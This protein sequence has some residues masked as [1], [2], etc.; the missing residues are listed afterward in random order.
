MHRVTE[1]LWMGI[2]IA[3]A[4]AIHYDAG[5]TSNFARPLN[6][7]TLM[8]RRTC[9]IGAPESVTWGRCI[10]TDI[11]YRLTVSH[12]PLSALDAWLQRVFLEIHHLPCRPPV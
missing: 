11:Y 2:S 8:T 3:S 5:M 1:E 4:T 6:L 7:L 10:D 9:V 12:L